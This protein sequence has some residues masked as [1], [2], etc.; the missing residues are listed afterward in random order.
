MDEFLHFALGSSKSFKEAISITIHSIGNVNHGQTG[1]YMIID[2]LLLKIFGASSIALRLPSVI[3]S[4]F[5]FYAGNL[6]IQHKSNNNFLAKILLLLSFAGSAT[7]LSFIGEARP[8][9]PLAASA[10][11]LLAFYV[12]DPE[13]ISLVQRELLYFSGI[14]FGA[15]FHPYFPLYWLIAI[16]IGY[17]DALENK[18]IK[19]SLKSLILFSNPIRIFL[20]GFIYITIASLTWLFKPASFT[21]NPFQW[22]SQSQ[23]LEIFSNLHFQFVGEL[24]IVFTTLIFFLIVIFLITKNLT[25]SKIS[26]PVLLIIITC[27]ASLIISYISYTRSY[28]IL[29]RQWSGSLA[30]IPVSCVWLLVSLINMQRK[31]VRS[32]TLTI[33]IFLICNKAFTTQIAL[34]NENLTA[35]KNQTTPSKLSCKSRTAEISNVID[36]GNKTWVLLAN[37]N[38][39]CGGSVWPIFR[40]YYQGQLD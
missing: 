35:Y 27:T 39:N 4:S 12:I 25:I 14:F 36:E 20:G 32:V 26:I 31:L 16:L 19:G 22:V 10:I 2:F 40:Q 8:Y 3:A 17:L 18:K 9:M 38:I 30:L 1:T 37:R 28:W 11:L 5:M 24:F 15:L 29:P 33:F 7:L 6:I 23:F 21:F 13:E 34:F